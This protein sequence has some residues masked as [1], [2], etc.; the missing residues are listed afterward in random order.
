MSYRFYTSL[1][2]CMLALLLAFLFLG[3]GNTS[4][5]NNKSLLWR[6]N[7]QVIEYYS[8]VQ[9]AALPG[10]SAAKQ[11]NAQANATQTNAKNASHLK[12]QYRFVRKPGLLRDEYF[13]ESHALQNVESNSAPE[14]Q[15]YKGN[16]KVKNIFANWHNPRTLAYYPRPQ[17]KAKTNKSKE[18]DAPQQQMGLEKPEYQ[19]RFYRQPDSAAIILNVG[20]TNEQKRTFVSSSHEKQLVF[21]L[22]SHL[23]NDIIKKAARDFRRRELFEVPRDS[24]I[25]KIEIVEPRHKKKYVYTQRQLKSNGKT[26]WHWQMQSAERQKIVPFPKYLGSALANSLK[27]LRI[28]YFNDAP[29][30]QKKPALQK[31]WQKIKVDTLNIHLQIQP[32]K[33]YQIRIRQIDTQKKEAELLKINNIVHAL[34]AISTSSITAD[35]QLPSQLY[36]VRQTQVDDIRKHSAKIHEHIEQQEKA[37]KTKKTPAH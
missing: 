32:D 1:A 30:L 26:D 6:Q 35:T 13:I 9:S 37:T 34:L 24:Y 33:R 3:P 29:Q 14:F 7:W 11:K 16:Y 4:E 27:W 8:A 25:Q 5:E 28:S 18:S 36:L 21:M 22:A 31:L 20:N 2:I 17:L 15:R 23:P 19:I 10:K 12:L